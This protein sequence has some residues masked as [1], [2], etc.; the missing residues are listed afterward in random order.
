M[1]VTAQLRATRDAYGEALVELGGRRSDVVVLDAGVSDSTRSQR[2]QQVYPERFFNVG[3][4]EA[5]LVDVAAGLALGGYRVFASSFAVFLA[6]RAWEQ[7]RQSIAYPGL[8]VTLVGTHAGLSVGEDGASAQMLEDLAIMRA[9]PNVTVLSPA[10]ATETR[11]A[12]LAAAEH[13]G[14]VYLRLT[15]N[16][17]PVL[18]G[19]EHQLQI[20]RA[21]VLRHGHDL[22]ILATGL[23]VSVAL[24][25][26]D[27]LTVQ[28][29]EATV[30][31]VASIKPLD[32][33]LIVELAERCGAL[34][35]AEDHSV[36]GGLGSAVAELLATHC[37]VPLER[38]GVADRFGCSGAPAAL[39]ETYGLSASA[40]AAAGRRAVGR[41]RTGGR[42]WR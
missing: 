1:V 8:P 27:R 24:E 13:P 31:N 30:V 15:R 19:P 39:L 26:A 10:D 12:V 6:G 22:A 35:T 36:I 37:P 5:N 16:P 14:P 2:F 21:T 33:R 34:V 11:L 18:F 28:E 32:E 40:I 25:A 23:M 3:I 41:K 42:R 17:S 38:V 4:A 20:G 7:I 9:L 29:V